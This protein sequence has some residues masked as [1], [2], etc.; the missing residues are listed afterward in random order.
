MAWHPNPPEWFV[1]DHQDRAPPSIPKASRPF[2]SDREWADARD[3]FGSQTA[4]QSFTEE[5]SSHRL[6]QRLIHKS[7]A[8]LDALCMAGEKG[9]SPEE[10]ESLLAQVETSATEIHTRLSAL[11]STEAT[12]SASNDIAAPTVNAS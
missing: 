11:R 9:V 2:G 1:L 7:R 6:A 5:D 8:L 10:L 4:T 3:P 12:I